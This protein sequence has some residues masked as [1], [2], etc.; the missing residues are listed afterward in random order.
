M[1]ILI[2]FRCR[3]LDL[4]W[5]NND[6]YYFI[7]NCILWRQLFSNTVVRNISR[8][9][10]AVGSAIDTTVVLHHYISTVD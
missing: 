10:I 9:G 2:V 4:L 1:T 7:Y 8:A 6:Y 3:V 5:L